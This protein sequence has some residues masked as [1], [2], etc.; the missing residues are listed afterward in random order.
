MTG[1]YLKTSE[2]HLCL[3]H[4]CTAYR[5]G[6]ATLVHVLI[7]CTPLP[8]STRM[9][10]GP[11]GTGHSVTVVAGV[12]GVVSTVGMVVVMVAAANERQE[13]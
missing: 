3:K 8:A 1:K 5:F 2:L 6:Q 13:S 10:H 9:V 4:A 11:R 12:G 7:A